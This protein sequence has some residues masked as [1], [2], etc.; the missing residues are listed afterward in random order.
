MTTWRY[1][2]H[3]LIHFVRVDL[4]RAV[5]IMGVPTRLLLYFCHWIGYPFREERKQIHI[6]KHEIKYQINHTK[7]FYDNCT[8]F[9]M[10]SHESPI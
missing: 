8:C 3:Y 1:V 7:Y 10:G 2:S 6:G 5:R 4:E 9:R